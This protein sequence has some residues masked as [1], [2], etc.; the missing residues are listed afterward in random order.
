MYC[1][2]ENCMSS[3]H[4]CKTPS[5]YWYYGAFNIGMYSCRT[6][7]STKAMHSF[8]THSDTVQCTPM[9]LLHNTTNKSEGHTRPQLLIINLRQY[10]TT[11]LL[12]LESCRAYELCSMLTKAL[13]IGSCSSVCAGVASTARHVSTRTAETLHVA[14]LAPARQQLQVFWACNA[15]YQNCLFFC[16]REV[17]QLDLVMP[18]TDILDFISLVTHTRFEFVNIFAADNV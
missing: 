2:N 5:V 7:R 12:T 9:A 18:P 13:R 1:S 8:K 15:L 11:T 14:R 6:D 16:I 10:V 3:V 4:P 17:S